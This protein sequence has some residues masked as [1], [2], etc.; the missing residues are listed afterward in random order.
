MTYHIQQGMNEILAPFYYA[1]YDDFHPLFLDT[2]E[3]DAFFC[4][5]MFMADAKE[6]YQSNNMQ[7]H[8][9]ARQFY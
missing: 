6:R 9:T 1:F 5:T 8:A 3:S 2:A 7:L 4:F